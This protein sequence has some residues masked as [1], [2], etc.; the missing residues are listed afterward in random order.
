MSNKPLLSNGLLALA[1]G[2]SVVLYFLK[3]QTA[4]QILSIAVCGL[5]IR[6][7]LT[8]SRRR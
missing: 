4:V 2:A 8:K 3:N 1:F 5:A 6:D 7:F